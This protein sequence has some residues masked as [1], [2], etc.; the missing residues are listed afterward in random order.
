MSNPAKI[1]FIKGVLHGFNNLAPADWGFGEELYRRL[2]VIDR[3]DLIVAS[4]IKGIKISLNMS[5]SFP[6]IVLLRLTSG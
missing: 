5:C 4:P 3:I 1:S 2:I 6:L